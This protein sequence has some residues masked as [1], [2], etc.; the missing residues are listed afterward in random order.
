M[1]KVTSRKTYEVVHD[2]RGA[3]GVLSIGM[4][5]SDVLH[6]RWRAK[7]ALRSIGKRHPN[8]RI[9]YMQDL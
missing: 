8:A 1:K 4:P 5:L 9:R 3:N 2:I 7:K 6:S